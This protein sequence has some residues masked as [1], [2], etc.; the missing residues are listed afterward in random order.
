MKANHS[1][2]PLTVE[3]LTDCLQD[4]A[5]AGAAMA[6]IHA[7][8]GQGRH[9]LDPELNTMV[10][11][12]LE[13]KLGDKIIIQLTTEAVGKYSATQQ[14]SLVKAVKPTAASFALR[15][16]IPDRHHEKDAQ[17]FFHWVYENGIYS[18]YILYSA[19]DIDRYFTFLNNGILPT[20]GHHL[21]LV[22]GRYSHAL[23]ANA[24]DILLSVTPKL[25]ESDIDWAV[26]AFGKHEHKLLN[27]CAVFG[28]DCRVGFENNMLN[29][30]GQK[31]SDNAELVSDLSQSLENLGFSI[32]NVEDLRHKIRCSF[33]S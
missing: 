3:E 33:D 29:K 7:R 12:T 18:Q 9:S 11:R 20:G 10:Y 2:V 5:T 8:D 6:H 13:E 17:S 28:A 26:C 30:L 15:E 32:N 1:T 24:S 22:L 21:L 16:L 19:E 25:I 23:E 14:M 31:A 27:A 4:C